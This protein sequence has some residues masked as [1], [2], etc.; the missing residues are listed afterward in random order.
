MLLTYFLEV[1]WCKGF[2]TLFH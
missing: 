1:N 2:G